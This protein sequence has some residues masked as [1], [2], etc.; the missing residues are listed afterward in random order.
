MPLSCSSE[1]RAGDCAADDE[2]ES[3]GVDVEQVA[4]YR[5]VRA[6][7]FG[8]VGVGDE[9]AEGVEGVDRPEGERAGD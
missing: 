8:G 9:V 5:V 7:A 3:E 2:R 1:R 4:Y 6:G